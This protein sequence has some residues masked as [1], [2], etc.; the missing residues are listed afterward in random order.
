MEW[1]MTL[2]MA[3]GTTAMAW[4]VKG[5]LDRARAYPRERRQTCQANEER[6]GRLEGTT[7]QL[8]L[9][10]KGSL[11]LNLAQNDAL[12][13][14]LQAVKG[15]RMNGNVDEAR[16]ELKQRREEFQTSV[17]GGAL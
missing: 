8:V 7:D 1:W 2:L 11:R 4:L 17:I 3:G 9:L 14:L 5:A 15:E 10:M 13:V 16:K 12:D 6:I